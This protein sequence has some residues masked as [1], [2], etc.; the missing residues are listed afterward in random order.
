MNINERTAEAMG[1]HKISKYYNWWADEDSVPIIKIDD[2]HPDTSIE[3]AKMCAKKAIVNIRITQ[4]SSGW[5]LE[6][7]G[8]PYPVEYNEHEMM[9]RQYYTTEEL[10]LKI[11][12][13]ILGTI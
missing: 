3:Q 7:N 5:E 2:W 9:L 10:P 13:A 1:W 4:R 12:E 6:R 11:C 8:L